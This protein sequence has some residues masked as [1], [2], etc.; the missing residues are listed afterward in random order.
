M[1]RFH[2]T[3]LSP[4]SGTTLL[5]ELMSAAYAW[6]ARARHEMALTVEPKQPAKT[7]LS[8]HP[9]D[10]LLVNQALRHCPELFVIVLVRDPRDIVVSTHKR[11]PGQYWA[12]LYAFTRNLPRLS[13]VEN[14]PRVF[15][16]KY[17]DLVSDPDHVQ[18]KVEAHFGFLKRR[19][20]FSD[21][22]NVAA[23]STNAVEALGSLRPISTGSIGAWRRHLPRV[24]SQEEEF[25]P[26][27]PVLGKL[28]Y[29]DRDWPEILEGVDAD[30]GNCRTSQKPV[31]KL[32]RIIDDWDLRLGYLRGRMGWQP[33]LPAALDLE[34]EK[35]QNSAKD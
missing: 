4:R 19:A 26:M 1:R 30:P 25:G 18:S 5:F 20:K 17:E 34:L 10:L 7:L 14:H 28:G 24:K 35:N 21:Y 33:R 15:V 23:P 22:T 32:Q 9:G 6:E 27:G 29:D 2:I 11:A 13:V 3:S 16:L 31:Y 12:N 8:K